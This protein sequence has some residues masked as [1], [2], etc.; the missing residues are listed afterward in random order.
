M[1][2][3]ETS[4]RCNI[5]SEFCNLMELMVEFYSLEPAT[6]SCGP[7]YVSFIKLNPTMCSNIGVGTNGTARNLP[8][9]SCYFLDR[10]DIWG[11][12]GHSMTLRNKLQFQLVFIANFSTNLLSTGA[13]LFIQCMFSH[14]LILLRPNQ[15]W[16]STLRRD[17]LV[18]SGQVIVLTSQQRD[19]S[20]T[21]RK[22]L[23]ARVVILLANLI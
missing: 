7:L 5:G 10:W 23:A 8:A 6:H 22:N 4:H 17:F 1:H 16:Q 20:T 18:V 21:L 3:C 19:V 13:L 12:V 14:Q 11:A 15:I 2:H 9:L